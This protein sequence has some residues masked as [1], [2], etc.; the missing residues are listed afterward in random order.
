MYDTSKILFIIRQKMQRVCIMHDY[1]REIKKSIVFGIRQKLD[2]PAH[3]HE[4]IEL[5][6]V[7]KGGGKAFCDGKKYILSE[8]SFFLV[9]PNQVHRYEECTMG[10]YVLLIVKPT[11]L[12]GFREVFL[13][14]TP[15]SAELHL[16][17]TYKKDIE[18]LMELALKEYTE[19]GESTVTEAYLTALFG[20][21]FRLYDIEKNR[22]NNNTVLEIIHYC[23]TH[24]KEDIKISSVAEELHL[25]KSSVSHIFSKKFSMNFCSYINSLRLAEAVKLMKNKYY[26]MT[27]ISD[28]CGFP[29]IRTFNRAF[30]KKYGCSP[31]EYRQM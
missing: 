4:D 8:N 30:Q 2:F 1:F 14:S 29:T 3:I 12:L 19:N 15:M 23:K 9:F 21:L 27:E 6:F 26:S 7:K 28:M 10:E 13:E 5:V 24:Y 17:T 25:S 20:K 22:R 16:D 18:P 11:D 31:S